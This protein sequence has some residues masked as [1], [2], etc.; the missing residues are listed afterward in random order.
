L[1]AISPPSPATSH[2][3]PPNPRRSFS[4]PSAFSQYLCVSMPHRIKRFR[5]LPSSVS[6]K[7]C[8]CHS[9]ENCR[10]CTNNSHFGSQRP[11]D[12]PSE[13]TGR[14]F[15]SSER[16]TRFFSGD[17]ALFAKSTRGGGTPILVSDLPMRASP[18]KCRNEAFQRFH[19]P[20]T[21]LCAPLRTRRLCAILFP[22]SAIL[23]EAIIGQ[24]DSL[25]HP[26]SQGAPCSRCD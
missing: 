23:K 6:C 17:S 4:I 24:A 12:P 14:E 13:R 16:T 1:S 21:L 11:P 10:V 9:Y 19:T 7:P 26:R 3:L 18:P 22:S 25:S 20:A 5:T 2:R 15:A 8:I